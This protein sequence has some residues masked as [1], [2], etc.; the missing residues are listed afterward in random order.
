[1]ERAGPHR[2]IHRLI[3]LGGGVAFVGSLSYFAVSYGRR[4][5]APPSQSGDTAAPI[6]VDLLLFTVFALHHSVFARGPLKAWIRRTVSPSLERSVYVWL[7]SVLFVITCLYWQP[8]A[9]TAWHITGAAALVMTSL[10]VLGGVWCVVTARRLDVFELAGIR[11]VF[12]MPAHDTPPALDTRGP[13]A[14]VRHPI[15]FGWLLLVWFAPW[16]NGT[17]LVFAAVSTFYLAIAIPLEERE[18]VKVFGSA[19]K[20]YRRQVRW[21]ML[22]G[23]Y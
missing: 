18:L 11:Q 8:V 9:G 2:T 3:G 1:M 4:F 15:Y 13:Y 14:F 10:Q 5:D 16:M 7:A 21:R 17:R 19:Y 23:V 20:D 6:L 22:P 12:G